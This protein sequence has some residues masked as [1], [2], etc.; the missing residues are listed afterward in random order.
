MKGTLFICS[1]YPVWPE[2]S[3]SAICQK[4]CELLELFCVIVIKHVAFFTSSVKLLVTVAFTFTFLDIIMVLDLKKN[5]GGSTDFMEKRSTDWCIYIPLFTPLPPS[6]N[7]R[8]IFFINY[9]YI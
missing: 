6:L 3:I 7:G 4:D 1:E 2:L 9:M 5:I 8:N